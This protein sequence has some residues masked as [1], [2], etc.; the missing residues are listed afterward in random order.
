MLRERTWQG[1]NNYKECSDG[2]YYTKDCVGKEKDSVAD[3]PENSHSGWLL[4]EG[5]CQVQST[6]DDCLNRAN[7]CQWLD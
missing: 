1:Q 6:L 3:G 2:L 5:I 7:K 4:E